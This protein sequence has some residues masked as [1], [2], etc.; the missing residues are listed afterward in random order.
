MVMVILVDSMAAGRTKLIDQVDHKKKATAGPSSGE[1]MK[2]RENA[3]TLND[4]FFMSFQHIE[5]EQKFCRLLLILA[6]GKR[7]FLAVW[8]AYLV[9]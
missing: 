8:R 2:R 9:P 6:S 5:A 3:S 1:G 4:S 7:V